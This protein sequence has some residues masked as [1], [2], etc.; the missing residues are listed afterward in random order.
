MNGGFL[1]LAVKTGLGIGEVF[2]CQNHLALGDD[3]LTIAVQVP[4]RAKRN[5][6]SGSLGGTPFAAFIHHAQFQ[7]GRASQNVFGFG[8]V[9][10][11][12]QL[13]HDAV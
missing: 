3:G 4:F 13:H 8:R 1:S 7:G 2:A 5:G 9:L 6:A 12:G 11:A 10:Y